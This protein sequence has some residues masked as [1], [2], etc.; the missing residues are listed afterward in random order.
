MQPTKLAMMC[1]TTLAACG[2]STPPANEA[3]PAAVAEDVRYGDELRHMRARMLERSYALECTPHRDRKRCGL[4]HDR[5][6]RPKAMRRFVKK[7]CKEDAEALGAA[8]RACQEQHLNM[9]LARIAERYVEVSA[10][11][12][13]QH[14]D[15]HPL[16]CEDLR[17]VELWMLREHNEAV[18]ANYYGELRDARLRHEDRAVVASERD[19]ALAQT[20]QK[21][22]ER[23]FNAVMEIL[24]AVARRRQCISRELS[25]TVSFTDCY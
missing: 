3:S 8:S 14:C 17:E 22:A 11:R 7:V 4:V 25:D 18:I 5:V 20:R 13:E 24:D 6:F 23:Q 21:G 16:S 19:A 10:E 2:F 12:L 15:A 9:F 1:A